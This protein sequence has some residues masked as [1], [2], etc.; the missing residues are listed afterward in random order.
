MKKLYISTYLI[1]LSFLLNAQ[2]NWQAK[3]SFP[4][5]SRAGIEFFGIQNSGYLFGGLDAS[6]VSHNDLW[7]YDPGTDQWM[8]VAS[9]PAP[10][11]YSPAKFVIGSNAFVGTGFDGTT[12]FSDWW[13]Y[14]GSLNTW[15]QKANF[16]GGARYHSM[17]FG[18]NNLGYL[19]LGKL[20][21]WYSDWYEY[22][23]NTDVW[24]A[25]ADFPGTPRQNG[26][27]FAAGNFGYVG[28]GGDDNMA[29]SDMYMYDPLTD[30][31]TAKADFP[32]VNGRYSAPYFVINSQAFV[33]GGY[34]YTTLYH[35]DSY[36][37]NTL[38]DTWTPIADFNNAGPAR[39]TKGGFSS[40]GKG[41]IAMGESVSGFLSDLLEYNSDFIGVEETDALSLL[42]IQFISA[43]SIL[44]IRNSGIMIPELNIE[45]YTTNGQLFISVDLH[46]SK[47]ANIYLPD[48]ASG[49]Y[50][51]SILIKDKRVRQGK[52]LVE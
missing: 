43:A 16:P 42:Q 44:N 31:W 13:E 47:E 1:C 38:T 6:G 21:G 9:M 51:Y 14:S 5:G 36:K 34:N 2:G 30:T 23:P 40:G 15:T 4:N 27:G 12:Y 26:V 18:L 22:N 48:L 19:G 46:N 25:K 52:F 17:G 20:G 32:D 33:C 45:V 50:L 35:S 7:K 39:A 10:G 28:L 8:Q 29:Y 41:Y 11:R 37:Y 24:T 49:I 3:R